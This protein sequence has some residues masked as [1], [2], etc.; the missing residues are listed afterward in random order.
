MKKCVGY[1][2][3]KERELGR[4]KCH[5]VNFERSAFIILA[6]DA[7]WIECSILDISETGV[8]LKIGA[9]AMPNKI[10]GLALNSA[11]SVRRVCLTAWRFGETM[12]A[13]FVS[14]KELRNMA[15]ASDS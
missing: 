3:T 12:G 6:P 14:A 13:R 11:G 1:N 4:R 9:L 7:P 5:R 8:C 15:P 10:F 2:L